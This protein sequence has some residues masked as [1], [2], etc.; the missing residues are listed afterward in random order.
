M[1]DQKTEELE[2]ELIQRKQ[3]E[4]AV[5]DSEEKYR[6][7]LE[8]TSEGY[9]LLNTER[10]TMEVNESLCKM[11]G[12]R[13]DE[14]IGKTPFDLVD[15]ENRKIFIEQT[16]KISTTPHRS[17]EITLKKKNGEDVY[18]YFN[19]TTIRD[20]SGELQGSFALITDITEKN[21]A[22]E[23]L[24]ESEEKYR[25]MMEAMKDMIYI[26]SQDYRV[27]YMNPTMIKRTGRDDTGELCFKALHDL[28]EKCPWC[29]H[30]KA[31]EHVETDIVSPKDN[32]S[33]HISQIPIV[34]GDGSVSKMSVLRDTTDF[35]KLENQLRQAQKME[36]IGT[37]AGGIAH[38]FN[39]I[40]AAII[41]MSELAMMEV[42][43]GTPLHRHIEQTLKAGLR[44]KYLVKQILA[45][46]RQ[47]DQEHIPMSVYPV[48]K[49]ALKL[50]RSSLPATIEISHY[51][52][53]DPEL[54]KGDPTEIHQVMMNLCT[55]AEYAMREKG[56][57]LN[58]KFGRVNIGEAIAAL[59]QDL[60]P[61]PY[62]R[63]EVTDTGSGMEPE[64]VERIFDPYFTTKGIGEG[65]GL[66]LAVIQGIVH[67]HGGAI[68]V[69]SAPGKGTIFQV[70]FPIIEGDKEEIEEKSEALLPTGTERILFIDDEEVLV[71]VGRGMLE[72][73]GYDVT[74]RTSSLEAVELFKAKP[75]YF[76]LVI[77]DM[78][79]PNMTGEQ[80]SKELMKIRQDIPIILCTGFSHII[81]EEKAREIGIRDF[82]MKPLVMRQLAETARRVLDEK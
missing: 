63:L 49:E 48:V 50:L 20:E 43:E 73:L 19:A 76:D 25:A 3:A 38:D 33:Y 32:R 15:D 47:K 59:H 16:S 75:G 39:N 55:N 23:S 69:E 5:R 64:T 81:S 36:A 46:S 54:I 29:M 7:L 45:F 18:T 78:S 79:M 70:F 66:G 24:R 60:Q 82:A 57:V 53:K 11:L 35:I 68:T 65:T 71:E 28:E 42:P 2:K 37:L 27:E 62:M 21:R 67:K 22:Q 58:V 44:A 74:V 61:G 14:M 1:V 52:K 8:T 40:L 10:K 30:D 6:T 41:G 4:Q 31:S 34:N 9:W 26:C 51:I 13:Q 72:R 17:Y 77:T 12:Y 80:L 56:G